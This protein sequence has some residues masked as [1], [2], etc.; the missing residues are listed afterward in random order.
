MSK[1]LVGLLGLCLWVWGNIGFVPDK[2]RIGA[3]EIAPPVLVQLLGMAGDPYLAANVAVWRSIVVGGATLPEYS[4]RALTQTQ[5]DAAWMNPQ[6]EDNYYTASAVLPWEGYVDEAQFI[7]ER[8]T[9]SR[10]DVLPA[11][12]LAFNYNYFV[13]DV[14]RAINALAQGSAKTDDAGTK[15]FLADLAR[16]W[17]NSE[18]D[19]DGVVKVMRKVGGMSR[20]KRLK[21]FVDVRIERLE[22]LARLRGASERF[23]TEKARAPET[24]GELID[25]GYLETLPVD[26]TGFGYRLVDGRVVLGSDTSVTKRFWRGVD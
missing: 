21:T 15:A 7:L 1:Y 18:S 16:R 5:V 19:V 14:D 17:R 3:M 25:G 11:F 24:L 4:M 2:P 22:G 9:S 13:G 20:S 10:Q 8:A 12:F 23:R 6:H 26:P